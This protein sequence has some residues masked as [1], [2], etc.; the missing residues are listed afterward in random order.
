VLRRTGFVAVLLLA[1]SATTASTQNKTA[2]KLSPARPKPVASIGIEQAFYLIR[3]TMLTLNDAN[4]SGN[5]SVLRD[6]AAPSFRTKNSPADLAMTFADLRQRKFD[7]FAAAIAAPQFTAAPAADAAGRVRLTGYFPTR[8]L[9]INFDLVY[10]N[11]DG[12][13]LLFGVAIAT[14][15]APQEV[16]QLQLQP[17]PLA[18]P[19]AAPKLQAKVPLPAPRPVASAPNRH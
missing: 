5:Y 16:A 13:W 11:V 2:D 9:R 17:Q 19:P 12:H 4:R 18:P 6:L 3:S 14:P 10:E 1:I 15:P 8:P 7:L